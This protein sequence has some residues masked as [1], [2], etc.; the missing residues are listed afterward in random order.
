MKPFEEAGLAVLLGGE[1]SAAGA[2]SQ[3][4]EFTVILPLRKPSDS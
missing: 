3:G 2:G 4:S 1:I